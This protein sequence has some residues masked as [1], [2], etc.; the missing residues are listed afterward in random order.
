MATGMRTGN[1]S[2][3]VTQKPGGGGCGQC[4]VLLNTQ[5]RILFVKVVRSAVWEGFFLI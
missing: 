3:L 5:G 4:V 2:S 1:V